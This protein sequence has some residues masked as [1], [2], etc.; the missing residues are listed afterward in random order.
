[1]RAFSWT[2]KEKVCLSGL[3]EAF[4]QLLRPLPGFSAIGGK[5]TSDVDAL[6]RQTLLSIARFA[7]KFNPQSEL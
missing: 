5:A 4:P 3:E 7:M 2:G 1:M 6:K